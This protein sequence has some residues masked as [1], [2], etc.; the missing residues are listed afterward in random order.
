MSTFF[1]L[2]IFSIYLPQWPIEYFYSSDY[3]G[4]TKNVKIYSTNLF[5]WVYSKEATER[6]KVETKHIFFNYQVNA[7]PPKRKNDSEKRKSNN[8]ENKQAKK[9]KGR[10]V[11]EFP[12]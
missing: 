9:T 5:V 7:V 2:L 8:K 1:K 11:D 3:L 12:N 4:S 10:K 6:K